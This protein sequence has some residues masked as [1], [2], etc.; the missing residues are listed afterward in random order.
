MFEAMSGRITAGFVRALGAASLVVLLL[1]LAHLRRLGDTL[2]VLV[3]VVVGTIWML[4]LMRVFELSFNLANLVAVPLVLGVGIDSGVHLVHRWGAEGPR[5]IPAVLHETGR[6]VLIASLTT[7]VG[8]GSLGLASHRGMSSLG[9][10]L[11]LGVFACLVAS[12]AVLPSVYLLAGRA[13]R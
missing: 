3:P 1:L 4:G 6:G 11:A 9:I 5:R 8:F 7:M 13:E 10:L 2:M 12:L